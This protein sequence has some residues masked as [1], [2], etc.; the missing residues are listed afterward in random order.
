V[1][2]HRE[3]SIALEEEQV[4]AHV[5]RRRHLGVDVAELEGDV[6]VHVAGVAV[7]MDVRAGIDVLECILHRLDR[8]KLFVLDLDEVAGIGGGV[9]VEG[10]HCGHRIANESNALGA[11]RVLVLRD[12]KNSE[13]N[14]QIAARQHGDDTGM[15][16]GT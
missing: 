13:G 3:V 1:L 8:R 6:L 14:R 15:P 9:F 12:R 5:I 11:E 10:R 2:L 16:L 4:L 7:V